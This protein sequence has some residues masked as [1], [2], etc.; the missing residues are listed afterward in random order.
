MFVKAFTIWNKFW[1]RAKSP[2]LGLLL[3]LSVCPLLSDNSEVKSEV[4]SAE[5]FSKYINYQ[6]N[7]VSC[8]NSFPEGDRGILSVDLSRWCEQTLVHENGIR[9]KCGKCKLNNVCQAKGN[10]F[11]SFHFSY[12][13]Y[14]NVIDVNFH[15]PN[16]Y[17]MGY[18]QKPTSKTGNSLKV[19]GYAQNLRGVLPNEKGFA[20][21][22][23]SKTGNS[24]QGM[25]FAQNL[26]WVIPKILSFCVPKKCDSQ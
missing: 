18:A 24:L 5:T 13:S 19:M 11:H 25:G 15:E 9:D 26:R 14:I 8:S 21:N 10:S 4:N 1:S 7:H 3:L 22:L 20:Q 12:V 16:F 2:I 6:P 17:E 23:T